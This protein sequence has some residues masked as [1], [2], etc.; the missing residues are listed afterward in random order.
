[1]TEKKRA[2][3]KRVP[4]KKAAT[5]K[6]ATKKPVKKKAPVKTRVQVK[7]VDDQIDELDVIHQPA[8]VPLMIYRRIAGAFLVVVIAVLL[9]VLYLSMVQAVIHIDAKESMV[10]T[11]F[12]TRVLP[13][14]ETRTDVEGVIV[15]GTLGRS[16]T[17]TPQGDSTVEIPGVATGT[18]TIVNDMSF[19]QP[20]VATTR[21]LTPEGVLFRLVDAV[22]V[23]AG[24]Q[25]Q[26]QVQADEEGLTG[27]IGPS[28]F[29]IPG[30]SE[31]RQQVVY[32]SS[33]EPFT[34]GM[35]YQAVVGQVDL[36]AAAQ[37]LQ[38]TLVGDAKAMLLTDEVAEFTG[39]L[40]EVTVEDTAFSIEPDTQ[41]SEF[42]VTMTV[43]V[44]AVLFDAEGLG[45]LA[46]AKLY[47]GLGQGQVF[48]ELDAARMEVSIEL[49]N[50]SLSQ[51]NILAS[52]DAMV[53]SSQTSSALDVGRFVGL[54]EQEIDTL[55]VQEGVA[56]SVQVEFFPFW[57]KTVPRLKDH[58]YIDIQ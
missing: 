52:L 35:S 40:F 18:V 41:A 26:A 34:G 54:S 16:Q 51:A 5:K 13:V 1:M 56:A 23:P 22:R 27:D 37:E 7:E 14:P 49:I 11:Q 20:L 28:T 12:I 38:E 6:P 43:T 9:G 8:V 19:D 46:T 21:L 3:K 47:E 58:V 50:D 32:A 45:K 4:L 24:G 2:P 33:T 25:V 17:F 30:L 10:S 29:I 36:D 48:S 53:I 44:K 31:S 55:L 15:S 57:I 42:D 39:Q